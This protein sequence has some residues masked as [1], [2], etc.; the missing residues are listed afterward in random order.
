LLATSFYSL[1]V[2]LYLLYSRNSF[3]FSVFGEREIRNRTG[4]IWIINLKSCWGFFLIKKSL[5]LVIIKDRESLT[6][7]LI[8]KPA[9]Y[10]PR[11]M[12]ENI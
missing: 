12:N 10:E 5:F 2:F 3:S 11:Y 9:I 7:A 6:V 1:T 4:Y 8:I